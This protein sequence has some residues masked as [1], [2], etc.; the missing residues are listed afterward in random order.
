LTKFTTPKNIGDNILIDF[1]GPTKLG[2]REYITVAA[3]DRLTRFTWTKSFRKNIKGAD[4][5]SFMSKIIKEN[6]L[7]VKE[8]LSDNGNNF[9]EKRGKNFGRHMEQRQNTHRHITRNATA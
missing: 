8:I 9:K 3:T 6:G 4:L 2:G 1:F 7:M 5:V